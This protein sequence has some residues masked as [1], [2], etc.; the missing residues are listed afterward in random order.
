MHRPALAAALLLAPLLPGC[1][2]SG[3][4]PDVVA[5]FY[6]LAYLA[7][8]IGGGDLAVASIVREGVEPHDYDPTTTDLA[9]ISDARLLVV[10]GAGF[11]SWIVAARSQ[12]PN[13]RLV[14]ATDGISL[15]ENPDA[16]EAEELP[17]D[18]HTWV[19]PVLY[20]RMA[21]TVESA[22]AEAFLEHAAGFHVRADTLAADLRQLDA[23]YRA[24]LANCATRYAIT[25]HAAF[26]Y[27][28]AEYNFTQIPIQGLDP[29]AEPDTATINHVIEEAK[30][31]GITI[32]FFEE[33]VSPRM[34]EAIAKEVHAETRVLSPIE[35]IPADEA[36][37]GRDYF[38][39]QRENLANLRDAMRCA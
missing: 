30:K 9:R 6:P 20:A 14:T 23:E 7:G 17:S 3:P 18:P 34:A 13:T 15:R 21:R 10:Q 27:L 16:A 38:A 11:E 19:D 28:A 36:A 12:A 26:G 32:I 25:G 1:A 5:T 22:M 8:R 31:H 39:V 2:S 37:Q 4:A 35:A 24:G 29:E 33:L